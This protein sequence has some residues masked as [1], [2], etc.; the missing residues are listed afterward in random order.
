MAVK[1]THLTN[2]QQVRFA[3][4]DG[5]RRYAEIMGGGVDKWAF[6]DVP[7]ESELPK[8]SASV[9]N[10]PVWRMTSR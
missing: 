8:M 7:G 3:N 5:A 2:G 4:A 6:T 1:I 9:V 10:V